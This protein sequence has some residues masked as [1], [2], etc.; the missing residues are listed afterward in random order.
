[1]QILR[2]HKLKSN[3]ALP[4]HARN[5]APSNAS[6]APPANNCANRHNTNL[7]VDGAI[8]IDESPNITEENITKSAEKRISQ[9]A[10]RASFRNL[11]GKLKDCNYTYQWEYGSAENKR[12]LV[13]AATVTYNYDGKEYTYAFVFDAESRSEYPKEENTFIEETKAQSKKYTKTGWLTFGL[14]FLL[15]VAILFLWGELTP[16][17]LR[18]LS[19]ISSIIITLIVACKA[20]FVSGEYDKATQH[21]KALSAIKRTDSL[22][23][24]FPQFAE[25][26]LVN[27]VETDDS[28]VQ[29]KIRGSYS[30][31]QRQRFIIKLLV[32][33]Q[34]LILAG[35]IMNLNRIN[36]NKRAIVRA[37]Q[38]RVLEQER[39]ERMM[40]AEQNRIE[41]E[42]RQAEQKR[43]EPV[44]Q[45]IISELEGNTF[46][47]FGVFH[48]NGLR[49]SF[50]NGNKLSYSVTTKSESTVYGI[51]NCEW[52]SPKTTDYVLE[53]EEKSY[54]NSSWY[55]MKIRFDNF[56][57]DEYSIHNRTFN[58]G[59][60]DIK[61]DGETYIL[62]HK[63]R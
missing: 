56:Y 57:S 5:A 42:K 35:G 36:E 52:S 23:K 10:D 60:L 18:L 48:D 53:V 30:F 27:Q 33:I 6:A 3:Q 9:V 19:I 51:R 45:W 58:P 22:K 15:S 55:D 12:L 40:I 54:G 61:G 2:K 20:M 37:E 11:S 41:Q 24:A 32:F 13:P 38:E 49:I 43:L 4:Y 31:I 62:Y 14:S 16:K 50:L 7:I 46:E 47:G 29:S 28:D 39:R 44:K 17:G 34:I 1:M 25:N 26:P 21:G 8:I 63:I 59:H